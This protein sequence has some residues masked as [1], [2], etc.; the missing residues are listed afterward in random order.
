MDKIKIKISKELQVE[1]S[2]YFEKTY[3]IHP[4]KNER[5]MWSIENLFW[6]GKL[7]FTNKLVFLVFWYDITL[8]SALKTVVCFAIKESLKQK[9][10]QG[11]S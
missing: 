7:F 2:A 11:K 3:K 6:R 4:A 8:P 5:D 9:S 1:V 10:L